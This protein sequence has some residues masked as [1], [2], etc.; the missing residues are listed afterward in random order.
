M[1]KYLKLST[2]YFLLA[3][4]ALIITWFTQFAALYGH[5]SISQPSIYC[6]T[7][8]YYVPTSPPSHDSGLPIPYI[9]HYISDNG[10]GVGMPITAYLFIIDC[11]IWFL[12][13]VG[14]I[15]LIKYLAKK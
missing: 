5:P 11:L 3:L 1:S 7:D 10:C 9:T 8:A 14:V 2:K 13:M 4:T 15:R 6:S 12:V